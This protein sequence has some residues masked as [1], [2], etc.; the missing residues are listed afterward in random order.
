MDVLQ[1]QLSEDP[2]RAGVRAAIEA[3]AEQY[4]KSLANDPN[5]RVAAVTTIPVVVHVVYRTSTQNITDAQIQSQIDVL[6]ADFRRLNA[7]RTSTPS[8]FSGIVADAEFEFCLAKRD[9]NGAATTGITRTSTTVT[10]FTDND[11]VKFTSSGGRNAW[12]ASSYLNIWVCPLSGG[13]LG[14]AQFPGGPASTD[15]VVIGY[16]Y[17]GTTGTATAPFN[18]GRTATHEVGHWLNLYHIWGDDGTSCS[19]S[20]A[21]SDTPN[22]A[23]EHYGCP[24]FPQVSC[25]NGPNGD[26]F[27]NYMD[28]TDDAC[29]NSF[30]TGQK[31]RMK[32]LFNTGG[33]RVGLLSSQGCVPPSGTCATPTTSGATSIT[34]TTATLNWASTGATSYNVRYKLTSSSTWTS[35]TSTTNSKAITGLTASSNYEFQV[36]GVCGSSTSAFSA[37]GTFTTSGAGC[38]DFLEPNNSSSAAASISVNTTYGPTT[39]TPR[40]CSSTDADWYRFT[41][42]AAAPKVRVTLSGLPADYDIRLYNSSVSQI[43]IS[44]NGGTSSETITWNSSSSAATYYIQVYGYSGAFSTTG[45]YTLRASTQA[46]NFTRISQDE[47]PFEAEAKDL[48]EISV[49]PNPASSKVTLSFNAITEG[50]LS[51]RLMDM[52]GKAVRLQTVLARSGTNE[53]TL[54]VADLPAGLYLVRME[55]NGEIVTRRLDITR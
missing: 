12:P 18:K 44:Q 20:D 49:F 33:S 36:Q 7:D 32:A 17:F 45:T 19:G 51:V 46:S 14:Y 40:I 1:R 29:M 25:S 52:T 27:M 23:D 37:S 47:L 39:Q 54:D 41:T 9:P 24:S 22:Q 34:T 50:D 4:A 28:Y 8:A 48:T 10:G 55:L 38:V 30:T 11:N 13:L 5:A 3:H 21:V 15:G 43:G 16:N 31:N 42:T 26:M 53:L 6:N 35:T 2:K